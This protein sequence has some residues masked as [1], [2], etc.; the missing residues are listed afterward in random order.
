MESA[1]HGAQLAVIAGL[2]A[3]VNAAV[4]LLNT[5]EPPLPSLSSPL[6][7]V[8]LAFCVYTWF[9]APITRAILVRRYPWLRQIHE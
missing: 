2:W 1:G 8:Y 7:V 4:P 3:L 5:G 9:A 6:Q